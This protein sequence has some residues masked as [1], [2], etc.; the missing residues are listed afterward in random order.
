MLFVD[1]E[2]AHREMLEVCDSGLTFHSG[3]TAGQS[4]GQAGLWTRAD[5]PAGAL[6]GFYTGRETDAPDKYS[7]SISEDFVSMTPLEEGSEAPDFSMHP[8][9]AINEPA[10]GEMANVF[11]RSE[12]HELAGPSE[13]GVVI[14]FYTAVPV[15]ANAEL[16]WHYGESYQ[17]HR[18][19]Y[20]PGTPA[21]PLPVPKVSPDIIQAL[22]SHRPD[23]IH[24]LPPEQSE[25]EEESDGEWR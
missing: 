17:P 10:E 18:H 22:L 9:A 16:K 11:A 23:A 7:V 15:S 5:L 1:S 2:P 3:D 12:L 19:G 25:G 24:R 14:P 8:L 4:I 21:A 6:L 13:L 20:M